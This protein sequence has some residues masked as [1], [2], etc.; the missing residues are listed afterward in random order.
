MVRG[1]TTL[2]QVAGLRDDPDSRIYLFKCYRR[3]LTDLWQPLKAYV[4]HA[5]GCMK[6]RL[7][8]LVESRQYVLQDGQRVFRVH[9]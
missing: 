6:V 2:Q 4:T 5:L 8:P 1:L 7:M 9:L 3:A